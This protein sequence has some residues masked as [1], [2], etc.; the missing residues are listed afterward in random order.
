MK[1]IKSKNRAAVI[2]VSFLVAILL[3]SA[4][5][6]ARSQ[7]ARLLREAVDKSVQKAYPGGRIREIAVERRIV[8][9]LE[10]TVYHDGQERDL[11]MSQ[12]GTILAIKQVID[13]DD[14]P[15][16]ARQAV[17]KIAGAAKINE[18][19]RVKILAEL[20]AVPI[21][22]PR[23]EYEADFRRS[24]RDQ[25]VIVSADGATIKTPKRLR[26]KEDD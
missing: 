23:Y 21:E 14:L 12:D 25:E 6:G 8:R 4:T 10:V 1:P 19:E 11:L 16:A 15:A 26:F 24:G 20:R 13:P 5:V 9:L 3:V 22:Q 18:A 7:R 2:A 17:K